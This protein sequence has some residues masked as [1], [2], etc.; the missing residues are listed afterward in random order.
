MGNQRHSD[1]PGLTFWLQ[2]RMLRLLGWSHGL[3]GWLSLMA[4]CWGA[5]LLVYPSFWTTTWSTY[6]SEFPVTPIHLAWLLSLSGAVGLIGI[7]AGKRVWR[8]QTSVIAFIAWACLSVY[9]L[10]V[11]PLPFVQAF[12]MHSLIAGAELGVYVRILI[13]FDQRENQ[14]GRYI[15]RPTAQPPKD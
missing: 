7:K 3:E 12:V 8:M 4:L 14:L 11:P 2:V 1:T 10:V 6:R 9:D 13:G 15:N 5:S